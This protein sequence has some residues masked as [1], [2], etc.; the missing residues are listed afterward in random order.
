MRKVALPL[1]G[2]E[3]RLEAQLRVRWKGKQQDI[4]SQAVKSTR[5]P[6]LVFQFA[7]VSRKSVS[8]TISAKFAKGKN[9]ES[10]QW[11]FKK[12]RSF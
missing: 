11:I 12:R 4:L 5:T 2:R 9:L 3:P 10:I 8:F 6:S 7:R 1:L